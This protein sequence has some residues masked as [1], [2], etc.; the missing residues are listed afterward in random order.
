MT[1]SQAKTA[2]VP[3]EN[4]IRRGD[5]EISQVTLRKPRGG[6]LRGLSLQDIGQSDVNALITLIPRISDP[7]LTVQEVENMEVEDLAAMGSAVFDFFLTPAQ[8]K[9]IETAL[10]K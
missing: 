2:N 9:Q 8:R 6:E 4:P 7:T 5:K 1:A 10:G 3:L